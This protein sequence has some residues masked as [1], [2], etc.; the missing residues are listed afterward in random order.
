ARGMPRDNLWIFKII[1]AAPGVAVRQL[2]VVLPA[3]RRA[4]TN[5]Q[6]GPEAAPGWDRPCPREGRTGLLRDAVELAV[7]GPRRDAEQLRGDRFVPART[8]ER[9]AD[10]P[11][12]DLLERRSDLEGQLRRGGLGRRHVLGQVRLGEGIAAGE[13]HGALD[14]VLELAHV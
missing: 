5:C 10:H 11:E 14:H 9:L 13:H 4:R 7:D 6:T 2:G 1:P 3:T 12:L 8:P